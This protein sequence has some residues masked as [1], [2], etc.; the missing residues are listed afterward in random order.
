MMEE[1]LAEL[2]RKMAELER[3]EARCRSIIESARD[4][5]FTFSLD[6]KIISLNSAFETITG[7]PRAEYI[8]KNLEPLVQSLVHPDESSFVIEL[9][10][11]IMHGEPIPQSLML[12]ILS[13]SGEY[14][15]ME[16]SMTQLTQKGKVISGLG[17]AHD[18]TERRMTEE[19]VKEQAVLLRKEIIERRQ[20]EE[21]LLERAALLDKARDAIIAWDLES[22]IAYWNEGAQRMYGWTAEEAKGKNVNRL[23]NKKESSRLN[24][25]QK[26]MIEKGEWSSELRQLT[27]EGKE[28]IV[29][30]RWTLVRSRRGRPKTILIINTDITEKKKLEAQFLRAQRL[31][32][33]GTLA[34]GLAH[35][36]NNMLT[37]I[38]L[39]LQIL[40]EK[41][42]DEQSQRLLNILE[43]NSQRGA[44]LIKQVLSFSRGI[45]GERN[46]VQIA[47]I[48]SET[49]KMIK[50]TFPGTIE[51]RTDMQ[52]DLLTISGDA[53]QLHQVLMNLCINARDAMPQGGTL[54]I[55]AENF[56]LDEI[57]AQ[58]NIE[59]KVGSYII[60]SISDTG[61]GISPEIQERI[62]E[63][64]FT[65]KEPGKGT[66]L[67]LSTALAI[68]KSHGGFM[69]VYSEAGKGATFRVYLPA[70][71]TE[72]KIKEVQKPEFP[73]GHGEL[74]LIAEDE[75][76]IREITGS[77]L[78]KYGYR[79]LAASHGKEA[80]ESYLK[81][82]DEIKAVLLDMVMPSMDG[83]ESIQALRGIEPE[84]KII[85][86]SG[87]AE[88]E[89]LA[90]IAEAQVQAFL[91]KPYTAEK[92]LKTLSEVLNDE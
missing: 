91:P 20:A 32:S 72:S 29:E 8:G 10:Q 28:I 46:P 21:G 37:P 56:Y 64:F 53:T 24:K 54:N 47:D 14:I 60:I 1:E 62:F 83:L 90:K 23:L 25:A 33:I 68:V 86:V 45:E 80:V 57:H 26:I 39:S 87:L 59:A 82:R 22:G 15:T 31:E 13:K 3:S 84:V 69:T 7:L 6:G 65:T 4:I 9:F 58:K 35:D 63:P 17:I 73:S 74:I 27:K 2:H 36:L 88:K 52:K 38:M 40:K 41:F 75:T 78:E 70:L 61:T 76:L 71:K 49:E 89:K 18:I 16:I 30:S 43:R 19:H 5:I 51:I 11:R 77:I 79:V 12:R 34:G 81:N 42:T 66:G 44:N 92:L 50:G 48:I 85:A 67:G 55:S